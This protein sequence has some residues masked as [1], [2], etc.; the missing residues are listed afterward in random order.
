MLK[1]ELISLC[2][3]QARQRKAQEY[4]AYVQ[5]Q[6]KL[7]KTKKVATAILVTAFFVTAFTVTGKQDLETIQAKE[8]KA[9]ETSEQKYIVRYGF[10]DSK[11]LIVTHDGNLWELID[12]PEYENGTEL[13]VLFDSNET[14]DVTDDIIIDIT[15]RR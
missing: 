7:N 12:G 4:S 8:V 15:E 3:Q 10:M 2:Q 5:K 14:V 1:T 11:G 13:R 6:R 9:M